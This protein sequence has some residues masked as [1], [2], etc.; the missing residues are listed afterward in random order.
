MRRVKRFLPIFLIVIGIILV[1]AFDLTDYFMAE[2]IEESYAKARLFL[3]KYPVGTPL[4]YIG[5][6]IAVVALSI[7]GAAFLT[8]LGGG[9]F[10]QP[11]GTIYTVAGA[12]IG[13]TLLFLAAK[14]A[15]GDFLRQKAGRTF[16]KLEK[17]FQENSWNYLLFLRLVPAFPFWMVNLASALFGVNL[18]TFIWTTAVGIAPGSFVFTQVGTGLGELVSSKEPLSIGAVFNTEL[19]IG[20]VLLG[21]LALLPTLIKK[22]RS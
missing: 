2:K 15:I 18:I 14:T 6:Y 11:M 9:L 13:A 5:I 1:Y 20:L 22:R 19:I 7:P 8:I 16:S 12:T 4:V 10:G 17:N 21:L 3:E